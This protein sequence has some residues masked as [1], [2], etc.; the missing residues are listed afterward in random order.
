MFVGGG[1]KN[2]GAVDAENATPNVSR[3]KGYWE[4]Y[5]PLPSRLRGMEERCKSFGAFSL[6]LERTRNGNDIDQFY[7]FAA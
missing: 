2:R 3:E 6:E 1:S 7:I 5:T 4:G